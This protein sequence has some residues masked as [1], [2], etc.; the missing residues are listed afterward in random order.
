MF[1]YVCT[2]QKIFLKFYNCSF[3]LPVFFFF[4]YV[5]AQV[6]M[7]ILENDVHFLQFYLTL[8]YPLQKIQKK[9]RQFFFCT[10][11]F[12][13]IEVAYF[14]VCIFLLFLYIIKGYI[15]VYVMVVFINIYID[16]EMQLY[17]YNLFAGFFRF[18]FCNI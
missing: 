12:R 18:C 13:N 10:F 14:S 1:A 7:C 6:F 9:K 15:Q 17:S 3:E 4:M 8:T 5:Y 11:C 16:C 2:F